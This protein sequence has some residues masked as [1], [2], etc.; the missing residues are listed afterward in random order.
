M[1]AG[2]DV[3]RFH[4]WEFS[5]KPVVKMS[6]MGI[7]T[8]ITYVCNVSGAYMGNNTTVEH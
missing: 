5:A 6:H 7:G 1:K 3:L 2:G 4:T 8:W